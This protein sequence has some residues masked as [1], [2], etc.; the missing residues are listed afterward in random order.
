M[1]RESVKSEVETYDAFKFQIY[2]AIRSYTDV[3]CL[4]GSDILFKTI[5]LVNSA[6]KG[7]NAL[8]S[9]KITSE[10]YACMSLCI[11]FSNQ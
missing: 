4:R 6:K 9:R 1:L 10:C 8:V 11:M 5:K 7:T 2:R 3:S